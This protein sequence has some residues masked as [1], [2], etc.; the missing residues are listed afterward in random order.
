MGLAASVTSAT[1]LLARA[2][3]LQLLTLAP[4]RFFF[5]GPT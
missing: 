3:V 4:A 5:L 2:L 1:A